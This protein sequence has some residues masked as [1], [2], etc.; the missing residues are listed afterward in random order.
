[1]IDYWTGYYS[2]RGTHKALVKNA[3]YSA[4][5]VQNF[6]SL[7]NLAKINRKSMW[8]GYFEELSQ[9]VSIGAHH[10]AITGTSKPHVHLDE[11]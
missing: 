3:F 6:M 5:V 1:M 7:M 4:E 10:D 9:N 8:F 11:N 2:N